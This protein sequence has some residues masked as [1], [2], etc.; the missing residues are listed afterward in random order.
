MLITK[1]P[2]TT[3]NVQSKS[4]VEPSNSVTLTIS[5][6]KKTKKPTGRRLGGRMHTLRENLLL[7]PPR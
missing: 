7:L 1:G 5:R 4:C 3:Y 6:E 2:S